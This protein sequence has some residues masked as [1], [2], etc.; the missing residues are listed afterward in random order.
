[1][2][3]RLKKNLKVLILLVPCILFSLLLP[4]CIQK[5]SE[6]ADSLGQENY[7]TQKK[8][9]EKEEDPLLDYMI[10][11]MIILGFRGTE[12]TASSKIVEDINTYRIGGVIL[13]DYDMP[14]KSFPRNILGPEQ[15]KKLIKDL[16]K[17][18]SSDLLITIDAEGGNVNRLNEEYGFEKIKSAQEMGSD[19]PE[20]T[21]L[22]AKKLASQ[23]DSLGININLA[24]VVDVD[25]NKDNPI[26]G[27][28]GRSFSQDPGEV[29]RHAA[30]FIEGMREYNIA[31]AVKHFPGH[32]S[33]EEDSHLKLPDITATYQKE[34]ELFPYKMLIEN[35]KADI[36]MTAHIINRDIDPVY[37]ATLSQ[38]FLEDILRDELN[39]EGV[40]ISDDMQMGAIT[41]NYG[42][43]EAIIKAINA[44]CDLILLSNNG[45]EYDQEIAKKAFYAIKSAIEEGTLAE[46]RITESYSRINKL[47]ENLS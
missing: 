17:L 16:N 30:A 28:L 36:I 35:N 45:T 42:F 34:A 37:P 4:S 40:I 29:H 38:V 6:T 23:L 7:S 10:G 3:K 15:T 31:A 39:Y 46:E 8:D 27:R 19:D 1:L 26:I 24:P 22:E 41:D 43:D 25:I 5:Q 12:V 32:G 2:L 44:G 14:T 18:S 33:S 20:N 9:T 47:K 13:F 11:Q 21:F